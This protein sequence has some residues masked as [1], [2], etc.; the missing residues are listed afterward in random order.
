MIHLSSKKYKAVLIVLHFLFLLQCPLRGDSQNTQLTVTPGT[1]FIAS[2]GNIILQNTDITNNGKFDASKA[3]VAFTG[4]YPS[5]ISGNDSVLIKVLSLNKTG[6]STSIVLNTDVHVNNRVDFIDGMIQLNRKT[7]LFTDSAFLNNESET[8]RITGISGGWVVANAP[9][10][11]NPSG[12]NVADI[13][14]VITSTQNPG[15]INIRRTHQPAQNPDGTYTGIQRTFF[16]QPQND[17]LLNATLRFYYFDAELNGKDENTLTLWQSDDGITWKDDGIS[18]RN[19]TDNYVEKTGLTS[20]SYFTLSDAN[21]ALPVTLVYFKASCKKDYA[22]IE[23]KTATEISTSHFDVQ[24]SD[25]GINWETIQ[26]VVAANNIN[27]AYYSYED[28]D[29]QPTAYYRLKT[30][31]KS[32]NYSYSPV[33][34]GGCADIAMPFVIYPNPAENYAVSHLS[35]RQPAKATIQLYNIS[36]QQL[37]TSQWSL[38]TGSNQFV[39]PV[40]SLAS[41]TYIVKVYVNKNVLQT[42]FIKQ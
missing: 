5:A 13:G 27:G 23:W 18:S 19:T 37:H 2:S 25:D 31:D 24:K 40:Q 36:G 34:S 15:N 35:V 20:L 30:V 33:F 21:N 42:K 14:A 3:N 22:L 39:L 26:A 1:D 16:I 29:P 6:N 38:Q 28:N 11:N 9:A 7:L 4:S 32:G 8:S 41:G 12:L 10:I 17:T